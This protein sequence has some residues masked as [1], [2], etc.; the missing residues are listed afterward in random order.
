EESPDSRAYRWELSGGYNMLAGLHNAA[1]EPDRAERL[2]RKNLGLLNGLARERPN[3]P[4]GP[5]ALAATHANLGMAHQ[6][7]GR[8][9]EAEA[10]L[11]RAVDLH[12]R[13]ARAHPASPEYQAV[14]GLTLIGLGKLLA[15]T[16]Q[17][18]K[19]E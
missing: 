17:A 14:F 6:R 16:G 18:E 4:H 5:A 8:L 12:E 10:A 19:A 7:Q 9:A 15:E 3:D 1:N 11:R 13:L 2:Y